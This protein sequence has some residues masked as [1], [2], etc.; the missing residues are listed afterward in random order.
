MPGFSGR[1][2]LP[3]PTKKSALENR[4]LKL[5]SCPQCAYATM[6]KTDLTRHL[7]THTGERPF[8]CTVCSKTF[9]QKGNLHRHMITH[10]NL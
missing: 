3:T 10:M 1:K 9:V 5:H 2:Y 4:G 8:M 7:R 6:I